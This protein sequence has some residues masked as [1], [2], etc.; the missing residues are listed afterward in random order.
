MKNRAL[1][2][3]GAVLVA[4][5]LTGCSP[6]PKVGDIDTDSLVSTCLSGVKDFAASEGEQVG[7]D[8]TISSVKSSGD[9][10]VSITV[11]ARDENGNADSGA[12]VLTLGDGAVTKFELGDADDTE[13][14]EVEDAVDRW[15]DKH[16]G[17]WADGKGPD[18]VDAPTPEQESSSA[19]Y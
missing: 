6:S 18:P 17:A 16:A 5:A 2:G 9:S 1:L 4:L 12:C 14:T 11:D 8:G 3:G 13:G 10:T 19:S 15:N 7:L